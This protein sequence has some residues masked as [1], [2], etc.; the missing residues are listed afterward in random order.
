MTELMPDKRYAFAVALIHRQR[1]GTLDDAADMLIRLVQRMQNAAREKLR[2]LQASH[3]E[4]SAN[5][6][7]KLRDVGL[8]YLSDGSETQKLQ[9]IGLLLGPDIPD[10]LQRCEEHVALATSNHIRLLPQC[11]RHPRKALLALLEN[12]PLAAASPD[13]SVV[14]ANISPRTSERPHTKR[15]P[16]RRQRGRESAGSELR[17]GRVAAAGYGAEAR[18]SGVSSGAALV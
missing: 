6:A 11:F 4:Q 17:Q 18:N 1:A 7:S 10:L 3:L 12:L 14:D 5:L 2:E 8:A 15:Y 9:A 16:S 13:N